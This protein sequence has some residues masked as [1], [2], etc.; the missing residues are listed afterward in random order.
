MISASAVASHGNTARSTKVLR[1]W[2]AILLL[3]TF[4]GFLYFNY[5]AEM[6][7][8]TR[9][10]SRMLAFLILLF[11][12]LG[13][14]LTRSAIS[15]RDRWQAV[16]ALALILI[17]CSLLADKTVNAF[18]LLLLSL[19]FIFTTWTLWRYASQ[20]LTPTVKRLG[21]FLAILLTVGYFDLVRSD[22]LDASQKPDLSWRWIPSHEAAFLASA[23][24]AKKHTMEQA[25]GKP[26]TPQPGDCLEYRGSNRDGIFSG[27]SLATDWKVHPP[28]L[29]WRRKVGPA[30]S[31]LI[32]VDGH[33]V[34]QEQRG[35]KEVVSCYDAKTG[36]EIWVHEDPIRFEE[37]LAGPGP[38]A[39]PTFVDGNIY[40]YGAKGKLNCLDA[41]TG[42]V[43][44][45]RDCPTDA[46]VAAGDM[47]QW[48]YACSPLVVDGLV[49]LF[50][51]GA[52]DKSVLAY[53]ATDGKPAW[54]RTGGKQSYS[55]PQLITLKGQRQILM[56]DNAA[57]MSLNIPDGE[58]L[59]QRSSP[60]EMSLPMLQP[61]AAENDTVVISTEPGAALLDIKHDGE[62][63]TVDDGWVNNKLRAGFNDFVLS[64]GCLYGLDDGVLCCIDLKS[65]ERLWKKG[66]LG[67]GQV[68]VLAD[69]K[70]LVVSSDKGEVILVSTNRKGYEELCRFQAIEGKTWNG[71]VIAN[72]ILFLRN[73]EEMAAYELTPQPPTSD[74]AQS[75]R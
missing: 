57:L 55:S 5:N 44:W 13:W 32:V 42:K 53:Q 36:D 6:G 54:T 58:L 8:T 33:L 3:V 19:P 38:R 9:F 47:P 17:A 37:A 29:L 21:F 75:T 48:G 73:G 16:A 64:D 74:S 50:A 22:G 7:M 52:S 43:L 28:K 67:H 71:L 45:S 51:G 70:L 61:H 30:W 72:G 1:L 26:W 60:S 68:V 12:Y 23:E 20:W 14:W 10:L 66:R 56:H 69:Q 27:V 15:W 62:K 31:G 49:I 39:T 46:G 34:T 18:A 41:A 35:E 11:G 2:P 65:G 24:N 59:W 63:W 40:A 4:W 25:E